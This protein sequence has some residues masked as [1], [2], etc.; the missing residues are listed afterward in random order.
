LVEPQWIE[1][2]L[3]P[4]YFINLRRHPHLCTFYDFLFDLRVWVCIVDEF[5]VDMS[6]FE[7]DFIIYFESC[8]R[9]LVVTLIELFGM[10]VTIHVIIVDDKSIK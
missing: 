10:A 1:T 2:Y 4:R 7:V 9:M 6:L 5:L 3:I 8:F